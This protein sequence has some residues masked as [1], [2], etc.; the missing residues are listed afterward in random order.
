MNSVFNCIRSNITQL[1]SKTNVSEFVRYKV[2]SSY[3]LKTKSSAVKRFSM[4]RCGKVKFHPR[5][6]PN[7]TAYVQSKLYNDTFRHELF[8]CHQ[9]RKD[10]GISVI[11]NPQLSVDYVKN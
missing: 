10:S 5:S 2:A 6:S 4:G 1:Y 7:K 3:C 9:I 8:S 11:R